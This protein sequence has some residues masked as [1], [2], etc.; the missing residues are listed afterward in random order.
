MV[1]LLK[2]LKQQ[3]EVLELDFYGLARFVSLP[4]P[5]R[6]IP[7]LVKFSALKHVGISQKSIGMMPGLDPSV[8]PE[9]FWVMAKEELEV[10]RG[11]KLLNPYGFLAGRLPCDSLESLQIYDFEECFAYAVI[12]FALHASRRGCPKLKHVRLCRMYSDRLDCTE[13]PTISFN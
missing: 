5:F 2:P 13:V 3:L 11:T 12:E 10:R 4:G 6:P 9:S 8:H 7:S 1:N